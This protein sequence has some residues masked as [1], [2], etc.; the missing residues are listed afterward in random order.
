MSSINF[1]L[2]QT[3]DLSHTDIAELPNTM[4][5]NMKHLSELLI[6]GNHFTS[7]PSSL[8]IV[9]HSL[10]LLHLSENPIQEVNHDSFSGLIK[11]ETLNISGMTE[12]EKIETGAFLE[13]LT[14]E[15]LICSGNK[16]LNSFFLGDTLKL[17][18]LKTF[19]ISHNN[20]TALNFGD[21]ED[22]DKALNSSEIEREK[23][24]KH[25]HTLK[26]E[27]NPWHCDCKIMKS[28]EF[29]NHNAT[30]FKRAINSDEARCETPFGLLSKL[31][32]DLQSQSIY[33]LSSNFY[34]SDQKP[35]PMKI[36]VYDPPQ[37]LRPKSVMLTVF[38]VVTVIVV[39]IVIG[40]I[41]VCIKRR[42]K[43]NE[44][45]DNSNP[46]RYTAVRDSVV[47]NVDST[48]HYQQP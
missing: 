45:S 12:L 17:E 48:H 34:C 35:K 29:F 24:F 1:S 47:P 40:F 6:N 4:F 21:I 2:L 5:E 14:L 41:I 15:V 28:L 32:Y 33:D 8:S 7:I 11:L 30:Y 3:L 25:L 22:V 46:I 19:D 18:H 9:G 44:Y 27:G 38:A 37:F 31:L 43:A 42:L 13:I 20:L 10:R 26:L 36:P 39:G 23:H 16:K